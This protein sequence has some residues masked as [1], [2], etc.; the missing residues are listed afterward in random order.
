MPSKRKKKNEAR[1]AK[2]RGEERQRKV[3]VK[4]AVSLLNPKSLLSAHAQTWQANISH[5]DQKAAK[6]TTCKRLC[7]K[8]KLFIA[9]HV[10]REPP[11]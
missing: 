3:K 9:K 10:T 6:Y 5:L 11:D 4:T 1:K 2:K 8:F 7:G